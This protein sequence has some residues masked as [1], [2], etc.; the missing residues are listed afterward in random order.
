MSKSIY[1]PATILC[2]RPFIVGCFFE[3]FIKRIEDFKIWIQQNSS[4]LEK[5][6]FFFK[7][8]W[9][10]ETAGQMEFAKQHL[11]Q[12]QSFAPKLNI[13]FFCN[14][15]IEQENFKAIGQQTLFCNQNVFLRENRYAVTNQK[16]IYNAVYVARI[17]PFKRHTLA[18]DIPKL[19]LIGD[20][21]EKEK[22]YA[23][24]IL[25]QAR[26]KHIDWIRK[27]CG[28]LMYRYINRAQVGLCLSEQEGAMYVSA[29]YALCGLP[30]LTTPN[31]GGRIIT[32]PIEYCCLLSEYQVTPHG[33]NE[34]VQ[35][36]IAKQHSHH[37][38]R[39]AAI[40]LLNNYREAYYNLI[41]KIFTETK[42][43]S[44]KD[45]KTALNF[46]HKWGLRCRVT[47]FFKYFRTLK[48]KLN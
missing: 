22:S 19:L 39:Q 42:E 5:T 13:I 26:Q 6:Y 7:L 27:V 31:K 33:V 40:K 47:P 23:E 25:N 36:L 28:I 3:D 32:L 9:Q 35:S 29:E 20:Y 34:G 1:L 8:G 21:S 44:N 12:I 2:R 16:K 15:L 45:L 43:G 10:Y 37:E 18:L 14:S 41:H 4:L 30:V 24:D 48:I 46:P 11:L 17:T 38:I